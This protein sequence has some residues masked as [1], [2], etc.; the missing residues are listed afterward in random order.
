MPH[1]LH[2]LRHNALVARWKHVL[3]LLEHILSR[4]HELLVVERAAQFNGYIYLPSVSNDNLRR[5]LVG[6]DNCGAR[7]TAAVGQRVV[8]LE[9]L[10]EHAHVVARTGLVEIAIKERQ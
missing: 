2:S 4:S 5:V 8:F 7:Q 1:C 3:W 6:H 10:L 9:G